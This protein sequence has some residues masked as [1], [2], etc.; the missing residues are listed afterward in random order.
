MGLLDEIMSGFS[1]LISVGLRSIMLLK[2]AF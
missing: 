2:E 1:I